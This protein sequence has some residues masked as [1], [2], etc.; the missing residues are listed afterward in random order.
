MYF[1]AEE[2]CSN[3]GSEAATE[4]VVN[5]LVHQGRLAHPVEKETLASDPKRRPVTHPPINQQMTGWYH[6]TK[7]LLCEDSREIIG[8]VAH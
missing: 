3:G 2:V 5:I 1:F 6:T 7:L 8:T 4:A